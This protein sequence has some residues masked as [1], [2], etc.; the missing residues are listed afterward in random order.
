MAIDLRG[1][2][3]YLQMLYY[4]RFD[5]YPTE[6]E[7]DADGAENNVPS[8]IPK[9]ID[10][11]CNLSLGESSGVAKAIDKPQD[12][13]NE[14]HLKPYIICG[15]DV[16]VQS[17]DT[18]V[19]RRCHA[20]GTVYATYKGMTSFSGEPNKFNTHMEFELDM[21]GDAGGQR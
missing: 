10:I 6:V 21:W 15:L 18:V 3:K 17:G 11:P 5:I 2:A 13:G 20:D 1:Y 7:T 9:A 14:V 8:T 12:L 19:V 4:D 16:E